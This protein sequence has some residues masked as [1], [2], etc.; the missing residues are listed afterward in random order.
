MADFDV[1]ELVQHGIATVT[2]VPTGEMLAD[3]LTK[4]LSAKVWNVSSRS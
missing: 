3:A 1:R 4:A 2:H